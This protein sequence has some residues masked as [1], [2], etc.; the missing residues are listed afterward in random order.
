[1][2]AKGAESVFI[3]GACRA[4]RMWKGARGCCI[5]GAASCRGAQEQH[6]LHHRTSYN[7]RARGVRVHDALEMCQRRS[8]NLLSACVLVRLVSLPRICIARSLL[9]NAFTNL[10]FALTPCGVCEAPVGEEDVIVVPD[11]AT[12][13]VRRRGVTGLERCVCRRR[14][15]ATNP[16]TGTSANSSTHVTGTSANSSTHRM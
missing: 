14:R 7:G 3:S 9:C 8:V 10:D 11:K 16:D 4:I 6:L 2:S 15:P 5:V 1:M 12:P 13:L